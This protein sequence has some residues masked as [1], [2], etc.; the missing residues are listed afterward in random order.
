MVFLV[1]LARVRLKRCA[2]QDRGVKRIIQAH[3]LEFGRLCES[4]IEPLGHNVGGSG[5]VSIQSGTM[6]VLA[7][8]VYILKS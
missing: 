8:Q 2:G 6:L 1:L 7:G 5:Y 4:E 3:R